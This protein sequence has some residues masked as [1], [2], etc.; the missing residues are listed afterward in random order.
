MNTNFNV[1]CK[2]VN[3]TDKDGNAKKFLAYYLQVGDTTIQ[4]KGA[5]KKDSYYNS[6]LLDAS[7]KLGIIKTHN[8]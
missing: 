8:E 7:R 5:D 2:W 3:Y 4:I 6:N 1:Y